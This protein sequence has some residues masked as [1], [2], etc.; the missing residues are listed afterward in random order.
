MSGLKVL[1][2]SLNNYLLLLLY[3]IIFFLFH[4]QKLYKTNIYI[5]IYIHTL[6]HKHAHLHAY[7]YQSFQHDSHEIS[8]EI[9][10][11]MSL[12]LKNVRKLEEKG[13]CPLNTLK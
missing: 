7:A 9:L 11:D 4:F 5:Y 12:L 10:P 6:T 3:Y 2:A 13:Y 8:R 1:V